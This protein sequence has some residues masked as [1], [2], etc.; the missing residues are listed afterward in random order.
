MDSGFLKGQA[1]LSIPQKECKF[2]KDYRN[3][4]ISN[5]SPQKS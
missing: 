3:A 2:R 4:K 1:L 5:F